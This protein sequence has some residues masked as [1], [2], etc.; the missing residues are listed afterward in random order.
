MELPRRK[1]TLDYYYLQISSALFPQM[2]RNLRQLLIWLRARVM[3]KQRQICP[4]L[5]GYWAV[6]S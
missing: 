6:M 1:L 5:I 4:D 3:S 2:I